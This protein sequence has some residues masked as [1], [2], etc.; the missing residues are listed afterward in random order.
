[1]HFLEVYLIKYFV[2]SS[3]IVWKLNFQK[4]LFKKHFELCDCCLKKK[5]RVLCLFFFC[6]NSQ[7][8]QIVFLKRSF[9][10]FNFYAITEEK[11]IYLIYK[12]PKSA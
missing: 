9:W 4:L 10:K 1:M 2:F 11:E 6:D 12:V 7:I 5:K 8:T 3:V